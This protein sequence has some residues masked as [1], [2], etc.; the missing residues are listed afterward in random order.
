MKPSLP[1]LLTGS[2]FR[3]M[4]QVVPALEANPYARG[5]TATV[6]LIALLAAEESEKAADIAAREIALWRA[7]L[8]EAG[9]AQA[10]DIP[11]AEDFKLSRLEAEADALRARLTPL[12]EKLEAESSPAARALEARIFRGLAEIA[13]ARDLTIP[14]LG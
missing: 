2:A 11:R 13:A 9:D 8:N 4:G 12:L 1:D 10:T 3:L 14:R 7:V 5:D 6:M